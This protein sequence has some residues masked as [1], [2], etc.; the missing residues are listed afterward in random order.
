MSIAPGR[1]RPRKTDLVVLVDR[2]LPPEVAYELTKMENF[3][4]IALKDHYGDDIAQNLP[5]VTFL[6]EAGQRQWGVLTQNPRMWQVPAER[7]CIVANGTRVFSLDNPNANRTLKGMVLGRHLVRIR[8]RMRREDPCFWRL[9]L[10]DVR[11]EL[12]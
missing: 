4:G 7:D 10:Q 11:K 6:E 8:R 5:D 1:P 9:R 12:A 3:Y 2:C